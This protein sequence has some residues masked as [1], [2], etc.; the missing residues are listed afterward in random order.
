MS[1]KEIY[2]S[3]L[4]NPNVP[5]LSDE[6]SLNYITTLTTINLAPA[7][8]KHLSPHENTLQRKQEKVLTSIE[9]H[10]ALCLDIETTL[11]FRTGGGAYLPGLD[12]NF[13]AGRVVTFPIVHI[14]HFNASKKIQQI[15]LYWDQGS[16]LKLVETIGSSGRNWPIRDGKDQARL[17]ASS[18]ALLTKGHGTGQ[19]GSTSSS[20]HPDEVVITSRP[21]SPR[22][23]VTGDPHASLSL[24]DAKEV[25]QKSMYT[26]S[27]VAPRTSAK[28]P[29]R[30]YHDLFVGHE[31]GMSPASKARASSPTKEYN[32]GAKGG[33]GKNYQPSRLFDTEEP[34]T[35]AGTTHAAPG[36]YIKSDPN[37]YN[38]FDFGDGSEEPIHQPSKPPARPK[39]HNQSQWGFEDFMTPEKPALQ[40][41]RGQNVRH[42]GWGDD[43][44]KAESPTKNT[45]VVQPRP[46]A[47][48]NFEFNDQ[49]TPAAERRP[50]NHPRGPGLNRGLDLYQN[51]VYDDTVGPST[52]P[53][54][55]S[56]PLST[57]TSLNDRRK[58]FEPHFQLTEGSP[59]MTEK[60]NNENNRPIPEAR[61]KAV[62][63]MDAQWESIDPKSNPQAPTDQNREIGAANRLPSSKSDKENYSIGG[64]KLMTNTGIK[65]EGDGM[66][67]KKGMG[68]SWGFGDES[69]EDGEGGLNGGKFMAG[70]KQQ[71]PKDNVFWDY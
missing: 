29:P 41:A 52:S 20:R 63:M 60:S 26:T 49:G 36:K 45:K 46:D 62:N 66:G 2:Q 57:V 4:A 58:D 9:S 12:D 39:T 51:N 71:A 11:E 30:D 59:K 42:L 68:R 1:L 55:K 28:P 44:E 67:G 3:F 70:K 17:I 6:A 25:D 14:V 47:Q 64:N 69:D 5:S 35:N 10:D 15:R 31:S 40:K 24:F 23:N 48:T 27:A 7:I 61:S 50:A 22:K 34:Q 32:P 8:V 65:T 56:H 54:K 38:H 43:D 16:L 33:A 18:A 13:V 19:A 37:K 21:T 53:D